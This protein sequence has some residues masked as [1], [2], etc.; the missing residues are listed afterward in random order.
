MDILK[1]LSRDIITNQDLKP[2]ST[3]IVGFSGGPDSVFLLYLLHALKKE[4]NLNLITAYLDHG[5]RKE[6]A[7]DAQFCLQIAEKLGVSCIIAQAKDIIL[8]KKPQG[9]REELGRLLRK[10]FF[11]ALAQQY[12][13]TSIVLAH[14]FDDQIET[15]VMRLMRGSGLSGL[16]GM[17]KHEG[18]YARPLLEVPKQAILDYLQ[19][20]NIPYRIDTTNID[21]SFL[22]NKIRHTVVPVFRACDSRFE[23]SFKRTIHHLQQAEDFIEQCAQQTL[24][25]CSNEKGLSVAKLLSLHPF[26]CYKVLE[27]WL[28][29]NKILFTPSTALF[30]EIIR[31]LNNTKSARHRFLEHATLIKK[32]GFITVEK[33]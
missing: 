33:V 10:Q 16:T 5:W 29:N 15:F 9:S 26:L 27:T 23:I 24:L 7:E 14:H 1:K 31:F 12:H 28:I 18:L 20:N 22:R 17:K 11:E 13:A 2:S 21:Q 3:I 32:R 25:L 19:A 8:T 4:L 30:N 6:S